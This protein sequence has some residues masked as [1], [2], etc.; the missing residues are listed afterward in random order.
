MY[1]NFWFYTLPELNKPLLPRTNW[2]CGSKDKTAPNAVQLTIQLVQ[3]ELKAHQLNIIDTK[4]VVISYPKSKTDTKMGHAKNQKWCRAQ[5][6][7]L[8]RTLD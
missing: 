3:F 4:K 6:G 5:F 8:E 1:S 2:F 7:T